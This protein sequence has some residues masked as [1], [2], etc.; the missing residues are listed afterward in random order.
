MVPIRHGGREKHFLKNHR[1]F[2]FVSFRLVAVVAVF[3]AAAVLS[4][5][6]ALSGSRLMGVH[7]SLRRQLM[8]WAGVPVSG[9]EMVTLF[10][11]AAVASP[12]ARI[13]PAASMPQVLPVVCGIVLIVL[14]AIYAWSKVSRSLVVF[15]AILLAVSALDTFLNPPVGSSFFAGYWIRYELALWIV[16]PW[17]VAIL[18]VCIMPSV[19]ASIVWMVAVPA[20]SLVWSAARLALCAGL[21]YHTGPVLLL[22]LWFIFGI[23][24]EV[25]SLCFFYSLIAWQAG[26][27]YRQRSLREAP[28]G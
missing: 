16:L 5:L 19:F 20:Y 1:S 2:R 15:V 23:M 28:N 12:I 8:E 10:G 18:A 17:I 27:L 6:I 4:T 9:S 14:T 25:L 3:A 24:A 13:L 21:L 11:G 26:F 7:E 22:I